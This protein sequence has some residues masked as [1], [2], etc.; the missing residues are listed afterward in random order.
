LAVSPGIVVT[1]RESQ[2]G[3]S[4]FF[5]L[6]IPAKLRALG[7]APFAVDRAMLLDYL[8]RRLGWRYRIGDD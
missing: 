5:E 6:P 1:A 8:A 2:A 4:G 3:T 7:I